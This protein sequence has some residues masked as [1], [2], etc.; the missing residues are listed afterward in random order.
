VRVEFSP[1]L[2][3]EGLATHPHA[4][5]LMYVEREDAPATHPHALC[6]MYVEREDA[7]E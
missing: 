5:C 6:S 4:L 3:G 7:P 1:L 2:L